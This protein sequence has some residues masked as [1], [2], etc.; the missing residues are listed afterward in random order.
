[1]KLKLSFFPHYFILGALFIALFSLSSAIYS[2]Y[3]G[4]GLG[5]KEWSFLDPSPVYVIN[6]LMYPIRVNSTIGLIEIPLEGKINV[7]V[8]QYVNCPDI[9]HIETAIMVTV[10]RELEVKGLL[11]KVVWITIDVNP[12]SS[13]FTIVKK[14]MRESLGRDLADKSWIW[15]LDD[16][17]IIDILWKQLDIRA[18]RDNKTGLIGHKAGFIVADQ[19][20]YIR[21]YVIPRD[22]SKPNIVAEKIIQL[23]LDLGKE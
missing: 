2:Y 3:Y 19:R 20:G 11:D 18:E 12:W 8:P 7:F 15:V 4:I 22:W 10:M 1:M 21:Y 5:P 23:L 9:C 14:Y 6:R 13:N 17:K 16:T